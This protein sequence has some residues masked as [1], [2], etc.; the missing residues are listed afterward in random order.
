MT[1]SFQPKFNLGDIVCIDLHIDVYFGFI[2]DFKI[3]NNGRIFYDVFVFMDKITM[4]DVDEDWIMHL[5]DWKH[6]N[7][8]R[9]ENNV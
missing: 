8:N 5:Q 6:L 4:T 9:T 7:P 1:K 2:K 3:H